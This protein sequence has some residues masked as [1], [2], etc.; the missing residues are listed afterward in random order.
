MGGEKE[1]RFEGKVSLYREPKD[2]ERID[3]MKKGS[4]QVH[5]QIIANIRL[6]SIDERKLF[7]PDY[8]FGDAV[9]PKYVLDVE[10]TPWYY[11]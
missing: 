9:D 11:E 1:F 10:D 2:V 8:I 5:C 3:L 6:I 4:G 7:K